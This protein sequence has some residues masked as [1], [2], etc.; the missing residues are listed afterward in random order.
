MRVARIFPVALL[1]FLGLLA[2]DPVAAQNSINDELITDLNLTLLYAA[3]PI[4]ILVE[5]VLIYAV[6][7]FK[8]N[9]E[10]QPTQENRRLEITWTVATAVVLLFVGFASYQVLAVEE[11][12]NPVDNEE[13]LEPTVSQDLEGAVGPYPEEGNA[14][15]I[16]V[17]AYPYAWSVTYEGTDVTTTNEIRIPTDRPVYLHIYSSEWLHMLHVPDMGIKQTAFVG[18]YNTVKTEAYEEGNYQFYCTEYCGVGH[19]QMNGEFIVM[20]GESYDEWLQ[21]QQSSE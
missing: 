11:I 7:K 17:E 12:G 9:D 21:E 5:A 2:A 4:T 14:V 19:S 8:D 15:E 13:R 1:G 3:I 16:E 6:V 10:P 20:D 18:Q